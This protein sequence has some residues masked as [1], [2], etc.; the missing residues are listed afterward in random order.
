MIPFCLIVGDSTGVGTAAALAAQGIRCEVQ[1]KVGA[2]SA[3][4]LQAQPAGA[5]AGRAVIAV[6]SND[7][8]NPRLMQNLSALRGRLVAGH[9]TWL[10]PYN[11]KAAAVVTA[12]AYS[13]RDSVVQLSSYPSRDRLHPASYRQVASG[14]G[15][16]DDAI[17]KPAGMRYS[18]PARPRLSRLDR[19]S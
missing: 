4:V 17:T 8:D 2:S 1:A 6:G 14:L 12:L 9:V 7:P 15:W 11:R 19:R 10:A 5:I 18:L 3:R 13:R 16:S